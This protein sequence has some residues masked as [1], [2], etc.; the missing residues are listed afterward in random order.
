M[1]G[2]ARIAPVYTPP[3]HRRHGYAAAVT[4]AA[5]ADALA[6]D[7]ERVVLY[8]D[9]ADPPPNAIYQRIGFRPIG[10]RRVVH[11]SD[12]PRVTCGVTA[13]AAAFDDGTRWC[14]QP[15]RRRASAAGR[16]YE[17]ACAGCLRA[18]GRAEPPR[19]A[20]ARPQLGVGGDDA[21]PLAAARLQQLDDRV[22]GG[23][24]AAARGDDDLS[25]LGG[26]RLARVEHD[27]HRLAGRRR[28]AVELL[29]EPPR[30]AGAVAP[31]AVRARADDVGGVHH[32]APAQPA[33]S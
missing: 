11:F 31:P 33:S 4:A 1:A 5:S 10:E 7:A 24:P 8:T 28:E 6:R 20:P 22:V 16:E 25:A 3:E 9:L 26:R 15:T 14:A 30:G 27:D 23:V 17:T 21:H 12:D 29:D 2:V 18:V 32:P 19:D 13:S